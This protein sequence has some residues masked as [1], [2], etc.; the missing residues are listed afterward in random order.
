MS[1]PVECEN[2]HISQRIISNIGVGNCRDCYYESLKIDPNRVLDLAKARNIKIDMT[3]EEIRL[4]LERARKNGYVHGTTLICE[5]ECGHKYLRTYESLLRGYGCRHCG[6]GKNENFVRL[7]AEFIFNDYVDNFQV[8]IS[9]LRIFPHL[10]GEIHPNMHIDIF[11]TFEIDGRTIKLGIEYNGEGHYSF[12]DFVYITTNKHMK[13]LDK[14]TLENLFQDFL[15]YQDRDKFKVEE[16]KKF[17]N[18]GYYLIVVPYTIKKEDRQKFI[19]DEFEKQ[20]G[21]KL[22]SIGLLD[23]RNLWS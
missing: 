11:S 18:E 19:I 7:L 2:G 9:M 10:K 12:R 21:I 22:P 17:N 20:T 1:V 4:S 14:I 6:Q 16:F 15:E 3:K 5:H 8:G 23:W 13:D